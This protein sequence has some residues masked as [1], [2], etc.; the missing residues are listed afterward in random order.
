MALDH[1]VHQLCMNE[2]L[3]AWSCRSSALGVYSGKQKP[4]IGID[5]G[6]GEQPLRRHSQASPFCGKR[7][8]KGKLPHI[9]ALPMVV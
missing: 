7:H 3:F 2:G 4:P 9:N 1:T 5:L 6:R 8:L